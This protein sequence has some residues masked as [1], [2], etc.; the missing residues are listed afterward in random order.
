MLTGQGGPGPHTDMSSHFTAH[1]QIG[2]E[3][4]EH[5]FTVIPRLRR[6]NHRGR[7]IGRE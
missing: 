2:T 7:T 1:L 4:L 3:G 6:F 5:A